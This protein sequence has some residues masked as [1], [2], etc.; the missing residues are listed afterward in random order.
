M[1]L[2][3]DD[4][5]NNGSMPRDIWSIRL[6]RQHLRQTATY[7]SLPPIS[8][9]APSSTKSPFASIRALIIV[10][11]PQLQVDLISSI[12]SAISNSRREPSE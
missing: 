7:L 12:V 3:Q 10:L 5:S 6:F 9:C 11:F 8:T 2:G 1:S 4:S